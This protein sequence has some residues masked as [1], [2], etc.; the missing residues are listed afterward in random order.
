MNNCTCCESL[1]AIVSAGSELNAWIA[2]E[3]R[4]R[5]LVNAGSVFLFSR[6]SWMDSGFCF[7]PRMV[8][9]LVSNARVVAV[10][11]NPPLWPMVFLLAVSAS[12]AYFSAFA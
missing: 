2:S 9:R 4:E 6:S 7:D 3:T 5:K 12:M 11:V 1:I 8:A 10:C